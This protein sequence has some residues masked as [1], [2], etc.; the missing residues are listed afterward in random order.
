[1]E[2]NVKI[3]T[4]QLVD[5]LTLSSMKH[6]YPS[7]VASRGVEK[8]DEAMARVFGAIWDSRKE[9]V[10]QWWDHE[11]GLEQQRQDWQQQDD[12]DVLS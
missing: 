8:A 11:N 5:E 1:M 12:D 2:V 4:Q 6:N 9:K 3:E 10:W 7:F